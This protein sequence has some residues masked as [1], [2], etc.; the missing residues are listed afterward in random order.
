MFSLPRMI[1]LNSG[2]WLWK[3]K[4]DRGT[5]RLGGHEKYFEEEEDNDSKNSDVG[6]RLFEMIR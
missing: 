5:Q 2:L 1:G 4:E 3:G 6:V